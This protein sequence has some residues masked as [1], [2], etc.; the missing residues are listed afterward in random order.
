MGLNASFN[1]DEKGFE[2]YIMLIHQRA[3]RDC[4][5]EVENKLKKHNGKSLTF[6][7]D[8]VNKLVVCGNGVLAANLKLIE[9]TER[10]SYFKEGD[11]NGKSS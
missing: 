4:L 8:F 7:T 11:K 1:E 10:T 2:T 9:E 3:L 5:N 6:S